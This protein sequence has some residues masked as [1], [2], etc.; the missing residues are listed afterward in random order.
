VWGISRH[1]LR[2][3]HFWTA[4]SMCVLIPVHLLLNLRIYRAELRALGKIRGNTKKTTHESND[5]GKD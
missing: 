3:M 4:V 1:L 5:K 2:E